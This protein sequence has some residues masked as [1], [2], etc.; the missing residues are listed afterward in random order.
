M[1]SD[2]P[3]SGRIGRWLCPTRRMCSWGENP[4]D[5][6][7]IGAL[8]PPSWPNNPPGTIRTHPCG[9]DGWLEPFEAAG[10]SLTAYRQPNLV[11][12]GVLEAHS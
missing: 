3:D 9:A 11:D 6:D 4:S 1:P 5:A 12:S 8:L 10:S 7:V 2:A